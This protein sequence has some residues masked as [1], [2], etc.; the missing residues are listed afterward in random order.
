SRE[1]V[2]RERVERVQ[3]ALDARQS[4]EP[5]MERREKGSGKN[6][7]A[8]TTDPEARKMKM[9]DGGF[10][11]AFNVQ[12]ATTTETGVIVG[13]D[14]TQEGTDGGQL[15]PMYEQ[16]AQRYQQHP[17]EYLADGGFVNLAAITHLEANGTATYL[18]IV[19]EAKKREKGQDPHA[20][21]KG[22][23]EGVKAWRARM[24][25]ENAKAIYKNRAS[26]AELSNASCRNRGLWSFNVRGQIKAKSVAL[27][28]AIV[29]NFHRL[30]DLTRKATAA[31]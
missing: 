26:S 19:D 7:R 8:S 23:S 25:T 16:I 31:T 10:R 4:L 15:L 1:R 3:A 30:L 20:P 22:D 14:V 21:V 9:G 11:P 27:W 29:H 5:K 18:P 2:A 17:Q 12:F 24:G 13:V 6:A 28:H